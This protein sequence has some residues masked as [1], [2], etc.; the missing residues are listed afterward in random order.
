GWIV[1]GDYDPLLAKLIAWGA[2]RNEAAA[3]LRRALDEFDVR[4]IKTNISLFQ[5]ILQDA[6]FHA[7]KLDTGYLERLLS[8]PAP[9][10][11]LD[12]GMD[13]TAER[14]RVAALAAG[15]FATLE[16]AAPKSVNGAAANGAGAPG[17]PSAWKQAAR[18]EALR[19]G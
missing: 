18:V 19:N 2:D 10:P 16:S 14:E 6:D 17:R 15:I 11:G 9:P 12:D 13:R 1:P 5:R 8:K 4:G 7:G 3:R